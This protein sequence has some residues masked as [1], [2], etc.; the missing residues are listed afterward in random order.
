VKRH[1]VLVGL[2]GSG[3]TTVGRRAAQLLPAAFTD[4]DETVARATGRP[5]SGVFSELGEPAFRRLERA[6][7]DGALAAPAHLIASGAGWVA[8]PGNLEAAAGACLVYL[9]VDPEQATLR[10][11]GDDSRPLL[12]GAD[13]VLRMREL[14]VARE[15]WY[16]RAAQTVDAA[17]APE[18]VAAA[19]VAAA[20]RAA[21]W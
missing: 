16:R 10:L 12:S 18:L 6:A 20:R 13:P 19:V 2:P 14:L 9:R 15:E 4:L 1:L 11:L 3:K 8:Q 5:I 7:M 17:G 21:G